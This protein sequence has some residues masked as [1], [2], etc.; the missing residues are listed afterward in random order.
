[1]F[2]GQSR[3][4]RRRR[5]EDEG[6]VRRGEGEK[7]GRRREEKKRGQDAGEER[8][9]EEDRQDRFTFTFNVDLK[10]HA[11]RPARRAPVR[12]RAWAIVYNGSGASLNWKG[13]IS[14]LEGAQAPMIDDGVGFEALRAHP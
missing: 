6:E 11:A 8:R 13:R 1:M 5:R 7:T 14:K 2:E 10:I 9:G 12:A 3:R 4:R